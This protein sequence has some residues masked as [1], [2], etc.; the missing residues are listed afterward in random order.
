MYKRDQFEAYYARHTSCD[1]AEIVALRRGDDYT[2]IASHL[3][4]LWEGW[5]ASID[6]Q[7]AREH[8]FPPLPTPALEGTP[9]LF[10]GQQMFAFARD[11]ILATKLIES[12]ADVPNALRDQGCTQDAAKQERAEP[13]RWQK[14][15]MAFGGGDAAPPRTPDADEC[16]ADAMEAQDAARWREMLKHVTMWL[17][18]GRRIQWAML[19]SLPVPRETDYYKDSSAARFTQAIDAAR[20]GE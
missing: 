8:E 4:T 7:A 2:L 5:K 17:S 20:K 15:Q 14:A 18:G 9:D 6:A 16:Y 12:P 1:V 19:D 11:A 13:T 10:T 3:Q